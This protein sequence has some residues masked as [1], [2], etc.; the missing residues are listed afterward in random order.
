MR[1]GSGRDA[2]FSCSKELTCSVGIEPNRLHK[3]LAAGAAIV[4]VIFLV[5]CKLMI[6]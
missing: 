4:V 3:D 6:L 1:D 2:A 5:D